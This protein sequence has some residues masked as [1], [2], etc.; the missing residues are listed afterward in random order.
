[1]AGYWSNLFT[2][3]YTANIYPMLLYGHRNGAEGADAYCIYD[4]AFDRNYTCLAQYAWNQMSSEDLYQFHSRYARARIGHRLDPALAAEAFA[5]VDQA[6]GAMAWTETVLDSL[7]YYWHTYPAA[8]RRG[9]Y[10]SNVLADLANEHMRLRNGLQRCVEHGRAAHRLFAQ[11]DPQGEEPLLAQVQ[12]ECDKLIGV[13]ET[14][15]HLLRSVTHYQAAATAG[16]AAEQARLHLQQAIQSLDAARKRWIAM[17][18]VQEQ[19]KASYL[20]PQIL[21]DLSIVLVY[22]DLVQTELKALM[23][24]ERGKQHAPASFWELQAN[25]IDLDPFVSTRLEEA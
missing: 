14:F 8:R 21:R 19:V 6:F 10:P 22:I 5:K 3:S 9:R 16:V 18:A 24:D 23:D 1:M 13:W 7:L 2:Q 4:P 17:I 11:A 25:Q 15:S 20:R 12:A